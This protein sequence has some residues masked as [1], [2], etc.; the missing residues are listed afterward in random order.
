M[1][2]LYS[3]RSFIF[4]ELPGNLEKDSVVISYAFL[5]SGFIFNR[6]VAPLQSIATKP[7]IDSIRPP[8]RTTTTTNAE[9]SR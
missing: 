8:Q 6:A 7:S 1:M 5:Y 9:K 2:V 3:L 4:C